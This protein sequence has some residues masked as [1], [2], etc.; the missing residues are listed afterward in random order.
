MQD[1][2]VHSCV[3]ALMARAE[4][5]DKERANDWEVCGRNKRVPLFFP[6]REKGTETW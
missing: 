5:R 3:H 2:R 4:V 6:L 1:P